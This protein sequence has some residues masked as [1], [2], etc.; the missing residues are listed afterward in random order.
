MKLLL[1]VPATLVALVLLVVIIGMLLPK[2]HVASR[3][4]VFKATPQQLFAL[5]DGSQTWRRNIKKYETV[6]IKDGRRQWRET[7]DH[8]QTITYEAVERRPPTLLKTRIVT[9]N[10]PY[11][12]VWT[13][14]LEPT[15]GSIALRITEQG[16]VYNP[17]FR[18]ISRF[19]IG[20]TRTIETYLRDLGT[21]TGQQ[22]E[23]RD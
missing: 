20:Q 5:I 14:N 18:F 7:D 22:V 16:E 1:I 2:T 15:N 23:I 21:A 17:L 6:S 9:A 12:G 13:I 19:V 11:S 8:G 10:L 4:A 3:S